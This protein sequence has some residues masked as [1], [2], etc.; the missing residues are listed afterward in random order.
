MKKNLLFDF[1]DLD[2][3]S[4]GLAWDQIPEKWEGLAL[5]SLDRLLVLSDNDFLT[6]E[7]TIN[8]KK[9]PFP[10]C[11]TAVPTYLFTIKLR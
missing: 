5:L 4:Q 10:K 11:Q 3:P 2:L 1:R 9:I 8:G 7:L 6:P